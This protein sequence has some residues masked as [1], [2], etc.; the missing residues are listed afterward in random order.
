MKSH[1]IKGGGGAELHLVET[2]N[3]AGPPILFIHGIS[4]S[5][6]T[7][8][9][10]LTSELERDLRLVAIDLRG[11]GDSERPQDGY[12]DS[13]LWAD[14]INAAIQELHLDHPILCGWSYGPLVILD[15]IRHYGDE[16]IGGIDIVGGVTNL[17]SEDAMS[18]L[19]PE[20]VT[21]VPGLFSSDPADSARSLEALLHLCFA[22]PLSPEELSLM[23]KV[24]LVVPPSVRQAMLSRSI[25]ND[26]L[27]PRVKAPVLISH[28]FDDAVVKPIAVDRHKAGMPQA[29]VH[30]IP[31]A[32]HGC[33]WDN[34]NEFNR[35]LRDFAH[36]PRQG[37]SPR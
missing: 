21:L 5:W 25:D 36:R 35:R 33:F 26:D 2:G 22:K 18:L 15:Y 19:T 29:Q 34:P 12:A 27:L 7:W 10:Q 17:G 24:S 20:F 32:G 4:Q 6:R 8:T 13:R 31:H 9:R 14:D 37:D 16:A 30:M 3:P 23:L 11:H 28:G 1:H